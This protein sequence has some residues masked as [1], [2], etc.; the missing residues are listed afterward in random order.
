MAARVNGISRVT[1]G[2]DRSVC[3]RMYPGCQDVLHAVHHGE[4]PLLHLY[5]ILIFIDICYGTFDVARIKR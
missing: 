4:T 1:R 5:I 3:P 2:R